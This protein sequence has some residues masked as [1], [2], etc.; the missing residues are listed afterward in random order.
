MVIEIPIYPS[1]PQDWCL[2]TFQTPI[3]YY[4]CSSTLSL[5]LSPIHL[6][7]FINPVE[8]ATINSIGYKSDQYAVEFVD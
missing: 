5:S 2:P 7:M 8:T 1:N 4:H 6:F 3:Q